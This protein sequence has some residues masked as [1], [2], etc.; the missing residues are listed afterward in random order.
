MCS[1]SEMSF[2]LISSVPIELCWPRLASPQ[3]TGP[4]PF[5]LSNRETTPQRPTVISSTIEARAVSRASFSEMRSEGEGE[6]GATGRRGS[7]RW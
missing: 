1:R 3:I 4:Y 5:S 2:R 6:G 7:N